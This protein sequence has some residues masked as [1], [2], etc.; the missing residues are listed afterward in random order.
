MAVYMFEKNFKKYFFTFPE[1]LWFNY[2]LYVDGEFTDFQKERKN[3]YETDNN[4]KTGR[5]WF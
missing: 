5:R 3:G 1:K 4:S 2:S